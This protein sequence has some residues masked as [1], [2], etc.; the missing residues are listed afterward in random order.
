MEASARS[1]VYFLDRMLRSLLGITEFCDS[2]FCILRIAF[3]RARSEMDFG[4]GTR[5][6]KSDEMIE[7]HF[8]NEHLPHVQSPFGWAVR[9]R[10]QMHSSLNLLAAHVARDPS[11]QNATVFCA[12]LVLPLDGRWTKCVCVAEEFGFSV[13]RL[14]RT[15]PQ[16][17]HDTLENLLIYALVWTFHSQK[18]RRRQAPL[19]RVYWWISRKD[20]LERFR[21]A[22]REPTEVASE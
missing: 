3:R 7:L 4:N 21:N 15:A 17:F 5:L 9:F 13:A 14:P 19:E 16:R 20:L 2:D 10:S 12:R 1:A 8:W 6:K 22:N 18:L 11:L